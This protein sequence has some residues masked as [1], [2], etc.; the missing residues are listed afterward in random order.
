MLNESRYA[1]SSSVGFA[2]FRRGSS[3]TDLGLACLSLPE[4]LKTFCSRQVIEARNTNPNAVLNQRP[5]FMFAP[6]FGK[7]PVCK[8]GQ[9]DF[10]ESTNLN[11]LRLKV[12]DRKAARCD[13]A[14]R[15][16]VRAD[17]YSICCEVIHKVVRLCVS[18]KASKNELR[19]P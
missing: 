11:K 17:R 10:G 1:C 14:A 13:R 3:S 16:I 19:H 12:C 9:V 6:Q 7:V 4:K 2:G 18:G 5:V 8:T 15:R